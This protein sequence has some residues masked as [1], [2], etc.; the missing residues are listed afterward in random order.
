VED[1]DG[2]SDS[3]SQNDA[4]IEFGND[5]SRVLKGS[6]KSNDNDGDSDSAS[7]N[8]ALIRVGMTIQQG[9]AMTIQQG[10]AMTLQ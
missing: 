6:D 3:A 8:D 4:S 9:L 10:L 1:S 7:Q 2:D 5:A